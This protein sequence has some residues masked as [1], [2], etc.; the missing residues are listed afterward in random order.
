MVNELTRRFE[1]LL[2]PTPRGSRPT[3]DDFLTALERVTEQ[4][5]REP[6]NLQL[7]RW[8]DLAQNMASQSLTFHRPCAVCCANALERSEKWTDDDWHAAYRDALSTICLE[9]PHVVTISEN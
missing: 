8:L 3:D 6:H 2:T 9:A 5:K 1:A 4:Q 7:A